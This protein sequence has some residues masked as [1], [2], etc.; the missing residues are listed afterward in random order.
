MVAGVKGRGRGNPGSPFPT[1]AV[2]GFILLALGRFD[3]AIDHYSD[4]LLKDHDHL[5]ALFYTFLLP[6]ITECTQ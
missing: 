4:Q 5:Q 3:K 6:G 1:S 2:Y